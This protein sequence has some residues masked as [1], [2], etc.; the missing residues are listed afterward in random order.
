MLSDE[1]VEI[2]R[3]TGNDSKLSIPE[4]L[5]FLPVMRI[6]DEAFMRCISLTNVVICD[7][8]QQIGARAFSGCSSLSGIYI[9]ASVL[10]I[11][12]SAFEGC[13]ASLVLI[14][15]PHSAAHGW[16]EE[17]KHPYSILMPGIDPCSGNSHLSSKTKILWRT[18]PIR[19][20][21]LLRIQNANHLKSC[22]F[23]IPAQEARF[24]RRIFKASPNRSRRFPPCKGPIATKKCCQTN[25]CRLW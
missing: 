10:S 9:P 7:G 15:H 20:G 12:D 4:S 11:A 22:L 5:D 21:S 23:F 2:L 24:Y 3:Y 14:V 8:I 13:P 1:A 6:G 25:F 16:A 19:G 17:M 18:T